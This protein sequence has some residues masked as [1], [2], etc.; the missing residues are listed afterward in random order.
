M[1]IGRDMAEFPAD[2]N[3]QKLKMSSAAGDTFAV[4]MEEESQGADGSHEPIC[5]HLRNRT[6]PFTVQ[7]FSKECGLDC[8]LSRV[9]DLFKMGISLAWQ[10][11]SATSDRWSG[12]FVTM[13]NC[14]AYNETLD[15]HHTLLGDCIAT[16]N[17]LE[18]DIGIQLVIKQ[19]LERKV[20]DQD[21][22]LSTA[23]TSRTMDP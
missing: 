12:I 11:L 7:L 2:F 5:G 22:F 6:V 23:T 1:F 9:R 21:M 3:L 14:M 16:N 15:A 8:T 4:E 17:E 13:G 10:Q 18:P 19:F 20:E